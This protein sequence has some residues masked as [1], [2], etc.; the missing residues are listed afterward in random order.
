MNK[1][2]IIIRF[3]SPRTNRLAADASRYLRD[4]GFDGHVLCLPEEMKVESLNDD[5]LA[6]VGLARVCELS[7]ADVEEV[8]ARTACVVS[9]DFEKAA[10]YES[11]HGLGMGTLTTTYKSDKGGFQPIGP[12]TT[13]LSSKLI[14]DHDP[15]QPAIVGG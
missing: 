14:D 13:R 4:Q 10:E 1:P 8:A 7:K 3:D 6:Q 2:I 9:I 12:L 11:Q 15:D 5:G